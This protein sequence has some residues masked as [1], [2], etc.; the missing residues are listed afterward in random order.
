MADLSPIE[1]SLIL[2]MRLWCDGS[3]GQT[4]VWSDL[5][6]ALGPQRGRSALGAFEMLFN[7]CARH[8]R[9]P[10]M[11]HAVGCC[12]VGADE[13]CFANFVM[14]AATG[15]R[16]DAMLIATLLVRA[17]VAPVITSVAAQVGLALHQIELRPQI[18]TTDL[19]QRPS[20]LH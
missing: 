12:C 15:E 14:T 2:Y 17:D 11:R 16:D 1:A 4:A 8:G 19:S 9:R 10:L 5:S 20:I 3:D 18:A 6:Q 13:A 7:L